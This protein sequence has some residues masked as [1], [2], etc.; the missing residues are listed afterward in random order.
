MEQIIARRIAA[1]K[2]DWIDEQQV[3]RRRE[4]EELENSYAARNLARAPL[5]TLNFGLAANEL[6]AVLELLRDGDRIALNHL[7]NDGTRR[8]AA[9]IEHDD[10]DELARLLDKIAGL[11]A[12]FLE[13]E[14]DEPLARIVELF[15][16]I[17]SMPIGPLDGIRFGM[18]ASIAP[19]ER[20]PRVFLSVIERIYGL[21][22][23]AVRLRRWEAIRV[24]TLQRPEGM[25]DYYKNW[26]R[27]ALIMGSRA[28]Q[29]ERRDDNGQT[30]PTSLLT[31]A[32]LVIEQ[33]P[34]LNPDSTN[35][36]AILTSLAQFDLL[37]NLTAIDD[38][39]STESAVFYPNWARFQQERIQPI[40][41]RVIADPEVRQA[42]FRNHGDADLA[43]AFQR[44]GEMAAKEAFRYDGFWGWGQTP[45]DEFIHK[46]A[47]PPAAGA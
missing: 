17:Y 42:I 24:L 43:I 34:A 44:I 11:G 36:Y 8:A 9:A 3:I 22:A 18:S 26:L 39:G 20:A 23:L 31:R 40:A 19:T 46:N 45:V 28:E 14:Q 27:H 25:G 5:G 37:A 1:A 4:R 6:V 16:A 30:I 21:G 12:V 2:S 32:A 47:P 41:N 35:S 38:S 15:A 33:E 10:E 13:Y 7:M 29:L